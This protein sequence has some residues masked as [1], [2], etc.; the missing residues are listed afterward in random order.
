MV[1]KSKKRTR[2]KRRGGWSPFKKKN[3]SESQQNTGST[4]PQTKKFPTK[5]G[6]TEKECAYNLGKAGSGVDYNNQCD[7]KIIGL[8]LGENGSHTDKN[9]M[10]KCDNKMAFLMNEAKAR[11]I[12]TDY[13]DTTEIL[14]KLYDDNFPIV[15]GASYQCQFKPKTGDGCF[16]RDNWCLTKFGKKPLFAPTENDYKDYP[17]WKN[18]GIIDK[19]RTK[20]A[21][22]GC[23]TCI[24]NPGNLMC[25]AGKKMG[26]KITGAKAWG[27]RLDRNVSEFGRK[28]FGAEFESADE[29]EFR[30]RT[31]QSGGKKR[32][33]S[34][35]KRKKSR[36]KRKRSRRRRRR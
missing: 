31:G 6:F 13:L 21:K 24:D 26:Q 11:G 12:K 36:R 33:K 15:T 4:L 29:S 1:K 18:M 28:G 5:H 25:K 10:Q 14:G 27:S 20:V 17:K 30:K 23:K 22:K 2:R 8:F 19:G 9:F 32:R 16:D 7:A 3:K 35:R 34:R